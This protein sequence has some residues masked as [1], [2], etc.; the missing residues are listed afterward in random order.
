MVGN[1]ICSLMGI[2][3]VCGWEGGGQRICLP[4]LTILTIKASVQLRVIGRP[5]ALQYVCSNSQEQYVAPAIMCV[6]Q[7]SIT[8]SLH[9]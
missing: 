4:L 9:A 2:D 1:R 6:S 3:F 7:R 8:R 5:V